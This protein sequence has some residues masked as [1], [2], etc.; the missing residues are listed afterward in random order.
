MQ[1]APLPDLG[2]DQQEHEGQEGGVRHVARAVESVADGG[3]EHGQ[4]AFGEVDGSGDAGV[5]LEHA[6]Q[7][8]PH[9]GV[10]VR[11][12]LPQHSQDLG[13]NG[14]RLVLQQGAT[15]VQGG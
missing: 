3:P 1:G 7:T 15:W 14:Q 6:E 10:T 4:H 8:G 5:G 11:A 12:L 9:V 2:R 13:C